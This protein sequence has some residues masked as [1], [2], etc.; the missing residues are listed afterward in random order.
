MRFYV[1]PDSSASH[2]Q[3]WLSVGS[4]LYIVCRLPV[5]RT[6]PKQSWGVLFASWSNPRNPQIRHQLCGNPSNFNEAQALLQELAAGISRYRLTHQFLASYSERQQRP[7]YSPDRSSSS[8]SKLQIAVDHVF[9]DISSGPSESILVSPAPTHPFCHGKIS[10]SLLMPSVEAIPQVAGISSRY[11]LVIFDVE[12]VKQT[13][14][15]IPFRPI[16]DLLS[17]L[18]ARSPE[19]RFSWRVSCNRGTFAIANNELTNLRPIRFDGLMH[20]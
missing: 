3:S 8:M 7:V 5:F 16:S 17:I 9:A 10:K 4:Y 6:V 1:Y 13:W 2:L 18:N 15:D 11:A 19:F 20:H 14:S 12:N